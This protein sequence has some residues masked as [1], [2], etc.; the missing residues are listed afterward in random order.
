MG[1][2]AP[3]LKLPNAEVNQVRHHVALAHGLA[4]QAIRA[5]GRAGTRV[6]PAE[7][8]AACVP[9]FD[10]PENVR[11]AEIATRE[12]NSGF[13]GVILEGKYTDGFLQFA[14]KDAPKFTANELK[15]ISSPN[16]F[17]GLNIYAPQFYIAASDKA[18]GWRVLPFPASFPHMNSDWLRVG[19]ETIY[20]APRLAAK[21][22]NIDTIYI[23]ENGTSSEDK[24]QRRRPGLRSRSHHVSAQLSAAAAARDVGGRAGARLFPVEPDGQFR[25]DLRLSKSAS[26]S[27]M[28][29]SKR[30]AGP[31]NS[32]PPSIATSWRA[33]RS[34]S[35]RRPP[36]QSRAAC[37]RVVETGVM[38]RSVA[39]VAAGS[40]AN[41]R[42]D[43]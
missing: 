28:S 13:L 35:E 25:M 34:A 2:D 8:I 18:P 33:T 36:P 5:Q 38:E 9:A 23:S 14:G 42:V 7:N 12:L 11:A 30:S 15:I 10:T 1:I 22:W 27:I 3:G 20:W 40:C 4:V 39:T 32:A 19:P 31:R 43:S 16:D 41:L 21:I 17:V 37:R 6:G 24:M 26:G 29:I